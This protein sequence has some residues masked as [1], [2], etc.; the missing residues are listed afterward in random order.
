MVPI[1][2]MA[3]KGKVVSMLNRVTYLENVCG[4]V[5]A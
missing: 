5:E 4:G 3:G 1:I 2:Y